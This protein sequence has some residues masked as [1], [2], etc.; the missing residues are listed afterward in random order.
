MTA[1]ALVHI[2]LICSAWSSHHPAERSA[3]ARRPH[4]VCTEAAMTSSPV[5]S[6]DGQPR[7]WSIA[8]RTLVVSADSKRALAVL[9]TRYPLLL[10]PGTVLQF[11]GP[12]GEL[13][14]TRI[15]VVADR[16]GGIVCAEVEPA[17]GGGRDRT[18]AVPGHPAVRPGHL[19]PVP[20]PAP[21]WSSVRP[22]NG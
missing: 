15:R 9:N 5:A 3:M 1:P 18:S 21:W 16:D 8:N 7:E 6:T 12:P 19:R 22:G 11:D 13:V 2:W 10:P 14:V 20:S 17:P 4:L